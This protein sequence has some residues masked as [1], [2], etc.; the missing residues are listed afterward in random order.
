MIINSLRKRNKTLSE[1]NPNDIFLNLDDLLFQ[2]EFI[3]LV[4][5]N[6]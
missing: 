4:M 2:E 1:E 6:I 5:N 3:E